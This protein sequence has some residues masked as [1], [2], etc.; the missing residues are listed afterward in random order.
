LSGVKQF[1]QESARGAMM[2]LFWTKGFEATSLQ[3][4]ERATGLNRS[5][6]YNAFGDK[7]AMFLAALEAYAE[8]VMQPTFTPLSDTDACQAIAAMLEL[9]VL[10][11]E[12]PKK[13]SG[14]LFTNSLA[15]CGGKGD[16]VARSL[17]LRVSSCEE[18]LHEA[19]RRGQRHGSIASREEPRALARFFMGVS[20]AMALMSKA[21]GDPSVARDIMRV[22]VGVL[23]AKA[24]E[25]RA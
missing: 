13:P 11:M 18:R 10:R 12:D 3:D 5:S 21:S 7:R 2:D 23:D 25:H 9:R 16:T 22:A 14:C 6:L 15:E 20:Q 24:A 4:L 17:S 8:R 1:D 19:I